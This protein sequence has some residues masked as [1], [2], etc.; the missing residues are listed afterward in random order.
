MESKIQSVLKTLELTR[1]KYW[2]IAPELGQFLNLLI[3]DRKFKKV[4]EIGTSNGYSGIWIAQ[5]LKKTGGHLYTIESNKIERFPLAVANFKKAGVNNLITQI[6]GHAP[7]DIP[8]RPAIFDMAFFDATKFEHPQYFDHLKRRIHKGGIVITDNIYSH[9]NPLQPFIEKIKNNKN[10]LS[11]ELN[12]GDGILLSV[13][14][15]GR[16]RR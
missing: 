6:L 11:V 13:N 5:A 12:I 8:K 1:Q 4:I 10:W 15:K 7:E 16:T 14:L 3:K 2:N 9:K